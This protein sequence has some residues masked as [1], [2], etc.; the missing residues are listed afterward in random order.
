MRNGGFGNLIALQLQKNPRK[1][2]FTE[3]LD[4]EMRPYSDQWAFLNSVQRITRAAAERSNSEALQQGGDLIGVRF[5]SVEDDDG[6][7]FLT[8]CH[9]KYRRSHR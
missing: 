7:D 8:I 5:A 1:S 3:F 4:D 9:G 6:L 2:G